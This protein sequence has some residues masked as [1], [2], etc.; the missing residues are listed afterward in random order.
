MQ[1]FKTFYKRIFLLL[2]IYSSSRIIFY[3]LNDEYF[4]SNILASLFEGI[5]FD[6]SA[7]F[8]INIPI[9]ILL[10]FPTNLREKTAY[11]KITNIIFYCVNIPFLLKTEIQAIK[12]KHP[13]G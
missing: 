7:L 6:I 8:Y 5:R 13:K 9:L 3:F 12:D 4:S 2:L 11:Q 1:Y 10:L